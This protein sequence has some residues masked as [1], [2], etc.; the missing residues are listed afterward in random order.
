[1]GSITGLPG[2]LAPFSQPGGLL[3]ALS[4]AITSSDQEAN[5]P[6]D[7]VS[8]SVAAVQSQETAAF[9][10]AAKPSNAS[11]NSIL[12]LV[13]AA[14]Q[15]SASPQQKVEITEQAVRFQETQALFG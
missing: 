7:L 11:G 13:G 9:P 10:G 2:S 4:S 1:M 3:S 8:L 15:T 5:S 6:V 12:S 14:D